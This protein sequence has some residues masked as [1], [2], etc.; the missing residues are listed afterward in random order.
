[1]QLVDTNVIID[2]PRST[3]PALAWFAAVS[4]LSGV[5]GCV[6]ME[7][8]QDAQNKQPVRKV[9]LMLAPLPIVWPTETNCTR[10]S[11]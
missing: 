2:I 1:M 5:P 3:A 6:V 11:I 4:E 8:C 10:G 7:F 9:L